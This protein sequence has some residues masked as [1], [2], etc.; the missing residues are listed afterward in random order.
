MGRS[1]GPVLIAEVRA[2]ECSLPFMAF[3]GP[4]GATLDHEFSLSSQELG[5]SD[6][7]QAEEEITLETMPSNVERD[8]SD[9]TRTFGSSGFDTRLSRRQDEFRSSGSPMSVGDEKKALYL[10][11]VNVLVRH[12]RNPRKWMSSEAP[13]IARIVRAERVDGQL[14]A[15]REL[16]TRALRPSRIRLLW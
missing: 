12:L 15:A 9:H 5:F 10:I 6:E 2:Q 11:D 1:L 4:L 13:I 14:H 7:G 8:M 3:L 16:A